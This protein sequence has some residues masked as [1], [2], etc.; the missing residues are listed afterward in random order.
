M[1]A[2]YG[3]SR[4]LATALT[5]SSG[6]GK[7]VGLSI[8][9][10][11]PH[12]RNFMSLSEP[13]QL[14]EMFKRAER[15]LIVLP[16]H[17]GVD[18]FSSAFGL[19]DVL[20]KMGKSTAV[21]STA[22]LPK[23]LSTLTPDRVVHQ[24]IPSLHD[25]TIELDLST[26]EME[27]LRHEVKDGKL[28]IHI[29]PKAGMWK[30]EHVDVRPSQYRYDLVICLGMEDLAAGGHVFNDSADFFYQTPIINIDHSTANEHYG[31]VNFV[32]VT[33]ASVGEVCQEMI[34]QINPALLD[35]DIA[36]H[37]LTGMISKTK[38][39]K[40]RNV[41]PKT[42]ASASQ[43]L[44][45]GARREE[46]IHHLYRTRSVSTLRLWG[47]ALARLKSDPRH[48]L[49]WTM[50]SAQDFVHAGADE[51]DLPEVIDE[52]IATTPE[53]ETV[54]L[55]YENAARNI[56]GILRAHHPAHATKLL[57]A[58]S[59]TGNA[60]EAH[61][62]LTATSLVEAERRLIDGLTK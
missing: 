23:V 60:E 54:L 29:T 33:A 11:L 6:H 2:L 12:K 24:N 49:V 13:Q 36:T 59:A 20:K 14:T 55:L 41:T 42:L 57:S 1:L 10:L 52:L 7:I 46:I 18:H 28:T 43:L 45:A 17:A 9:C 8:A 61:I 19:S 44:E 53:A 15:P 34:L 16:E 37:F 58:F 26:A 3:K 50:L 4:P 62:C 32:N 40:T 35:A 5:L 51:A 30:T 31:Q 22:P 39:F 47:R 56:C 38:S 48:R 25:L 21:V 27:S